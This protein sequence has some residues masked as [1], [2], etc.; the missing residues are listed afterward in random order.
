ML[1]PVLTEPFGWPFMMGEVPL[2]VPLLSAPIVAEGRDGGWTGEVD[3]LAAD[4]E[5]RA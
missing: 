1:D 2:G 3:F 5:A 4:G